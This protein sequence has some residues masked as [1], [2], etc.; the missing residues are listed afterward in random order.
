MY[1]SEQVQIL[2]A[3]QLQS[4]HSQFNSINEQLAQLILKKKYKKIYALLSQ[5][6]DRYDQCSQIHLNDRIHFQNILLKSLNKIFKKCI[7]KDMSQNNIIDIKI[8]KQK[9]VKYLEI[10]PILISK[11]TSNLDMI[12]I[13]TKHTIREQIRN[14]I[15]QD[16]LSKQILISNNTQLRLSQIVRKFCLEQEYDS[17]LQNIMI[18]F[19]FLS[20]QD[21]Q[22]QEKVKYAKLSYDVSKILIQGKGKRASKLYNYILCATNL[23]TKCFENNIDTIKE[24]LEEV[25]CSI[26]INYLI[27]LV[28]QIETNNEFK[29]KLKCKWKFIRLLKPLIWFW[30]QSIYYYQSIFQ[31]EKCQTIMNLLKWL[32]FYYLLQNDELVDYIQ[33]VST[34]T[35]SK[36]KEFIIFNSVI[37]SICLDDEV[38]MPRLKILMRDI[39]EQNKEKSNY[40]QTINYYYNMNDKNTPNQPNFYYCNP[41]VQAQLIKQLDIPFID[42]PI[43]N[44]SLMD[45]RQSSKTLK[46]PK[47]LS[48]SF[49]Q[50][51]QNLFRRSI[52][53]YSTSFSERKHQSQSYHI[54][55]TQQIQENTVP[56]LDKIIKK[57]IEQNMNLNNIDDN[58]SQQQQ[59]LTKEKLKQKEND[60]YKKLLKFKTQSSNFQSKIKR[61]SNQELITKLDLQ[62]KIIERQTQLDSKNQ[63]NYNFQIKQNDQNIS[64]LSFEKPGVELTPLQKLKKII[65]KHH[66]VF[67]LQKLRNKLKQS[68]KWY[69]KAQSS[70]RILNNSTHQKINIGRSVMRL[71]SK[72]QQLI[73]L[74][75]I[76]YRSQS[77]LR[78]KLSETQLQLET[79]DDRM[80][81]VS[82]RIKQSRQSVDES[83]RLDNKYQ[84]LS[85]S[86]IKQEKSKKQI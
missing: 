80:K 81:N 18:A 12:Q 56:M 51:Y 27:Y 72:E 2:N 83:L 21:F 46:C 39:Q 77:L 73:D 79:I 3:T 48:S 42:V 65:F 36:Y 61:K 74:N 59:L 25:N 64:L 53:Q 55:Q 70:S 54:Q 57:L 76:R 4:V 75:Y 38:G 71:K 58:K 10:Y 67:S 9:I 29:I 14:S 16:Q 49:N 8:W 52:T 41:Q 11:L 43:E 1:N 26:I 7:L 30:M 86:I 15:F 22:P 82:T 17:Y 78:K 68:K 47:R 5:F 20:Y 50:N 63:Q 33:N 40:K 35:Y 13:E 69:N 44:L 32:S 31:F 85:R 6:F 19:R 37:E 66:E 62:I 24:V 28:Q 34:L 23:L 60:F 84:I 45:T